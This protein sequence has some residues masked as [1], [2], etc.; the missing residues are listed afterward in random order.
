[1]TF[2]PAADG[3]LQEEAGSLQFGDYQGEASRRYGIAIDP[4]G[5]AMVH[6]ADGRPFHVLDLSS[7]R[8]DVLH[9]CADDIYRGRYRVLQ[10]NCFWVT[11]HVTGP[12]KHYRLATRHVR[13]ARNA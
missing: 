11:W 6:H 5:A 2:R 4:S 9:H 1:M 13:S 3:L 10:A 8:G 7:G 12:R